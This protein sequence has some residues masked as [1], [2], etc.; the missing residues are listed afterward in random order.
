MA[1]LVTGASGF[2]GGRLAQILVERSEPV[3]VFARPAANLLHLQGLPLEIV[4]GGFVDSGALEAA[5]RGA[6]EIYHCAGCS[7]DWA[8]WPVYYEGNVTGLENLLRVAAA[9]RGLRRFVHVST[10]DIYG[11]PRDPCD[12]THPSTDVGL[13]Y[14][15][16]K[17]LGE[18]RVWAAARAGLP[19]TVIRPAS[20]YGPRG[21]A[22]VRDIAALLG[23]RMMAVVD[24]GRT[25]GGFC[26]VDNVARGMVAA[27]HARIAGGRAY[28]LADGTGITWRQYVDALADALGLA[29]AWIDFP[30]PAAYAAARAGEAL[31]SGLRLPGEPPLTRHAVL[32]LSRNQE[33]PA[34]RAEADF[35]YAP[36]VG[37]NEGL[38]RTAEWLQNRAHPR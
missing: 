4:H 7:T 27:A 11:Y 32:I 1:V 37:F 36:A 22:F 19:V 5:V 12:E 29:R 14:N 2:L 10:T 30:A 13:P 3:R 15:R 16:S 20:I 21:K 38:A 28:N 23:K 26:Y 25:P 18:D 8:P 31:Y 34:A 9:E 35:G 6:T 33:Y 24:G 17:I